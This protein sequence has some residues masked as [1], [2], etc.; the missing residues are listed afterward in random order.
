V[1]F[2]IFVVKMFWFRLVLIMKKGEQK[3]E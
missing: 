3:K 2:A 1:Y